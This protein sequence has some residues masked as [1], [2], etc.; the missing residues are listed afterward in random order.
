MVPRVPAT[1]M[2]TVMTGIASATF[3]VQTRRIAPARDHTTAQTQTNTT[4]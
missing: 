2:E 1:A 4:N 3:L